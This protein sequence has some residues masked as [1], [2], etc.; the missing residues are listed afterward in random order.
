MGLIIQKFGGSSLADFEC[1]RRVLSTIKHTRQAGHQPVVV[2]SAQKGVTDSLLNNA[3]AISPFPNP[4]LL[5]SLLATGELQMAAILCLALQAEGIVARP[6]SGREAGIVTNDNHTN[7]AIISL[8]PGGLK[9]ALQEGVLPVVAGFQGVTQSGRTSTLGRGGSDLTALAIAAAL[10]AKACEI[11][12]DVPGVFTADPRI[13]PNARLIPSISIHDLAELSSLGAKV[14]QFRSVEF[15]RRAGIAFT[16]KSTFE[17]G[18]GSCVGEV[19]N[20]I[21]ALALKTTCVEVSI[22][23]INILK[24]NT[25]LERLSWQRLLV[26]AVQWVDGKMHFIVSQKAFWDLHLICESLG[27][28]PLLH[29]PVGMLSWVS[30][31]GHSSQ[32]SLLVSKHLSELDIQRVVYGK[33]RVSYLLSIEQ[34]HIA[35]CLLHDVLG[36][37]SLVRQEEAVSY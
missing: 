7:A 32:K 12:T 2:V 23:H 24:W 29:G 14:M 11:Y 8:N 4:S 17:E 19:Q 31:Q 37:G 1:I 25:L 18:V 22:P 9:E 10:D 34:C 27:L 6:F 33:K 5:D 30:S 36:L 26:D 20:P 16:I 21:E 3:S 28:S 13:V 15:A 35:M